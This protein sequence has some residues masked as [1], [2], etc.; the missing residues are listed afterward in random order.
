MTV[1]HADKNEREFKKLRSIEDKDLAM[2]IKITCARVI[3]A[4]RIQELYPYLHILLSERQIRLLQ[5]AIESAGQ[6]HNDEFIPLIIRFLKNQ[7]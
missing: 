1:F 3:G 7:N 5:V 6:S 4:A 2:T